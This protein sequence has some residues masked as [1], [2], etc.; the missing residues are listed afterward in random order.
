M[1]S[2]THAVSLMGEPLKILKVCGG[3]YECP[4][5]SDGK[6]L[7][8]LVG[9]AGRYTTS[10]HIQKQ[11]VGDVYVN[12]AKAEECPHVLA[13]FSRL[14]AAKSA[15]FSDTDTLCGVPLG[16]YGLSQM[17]GLT[18]DRRVIK[19]EKKVTALADQNNREQSN[20]VFGR[21]SIGKGE[22]IVIVEDVCNNFSTTKKLIELISQA[23]GIVS[24]IVCFLNRS[25]DVKD[26]Y[27][28]KDSIGIPVVSLVYKPILE[29]QQ[30]DPAVAQDI[31][32]GNVAWKPKDEWT[33]LIDAMAW[34]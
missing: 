24:A 5:A 20:L 19:V 3:Y 29:Y 32:D 22:K 28:M 6:R 27:V 15:I 7:G 12:F 21:H 11:W 1:L 2:P 30:D 34:K 18:L 4:K 23:G 16:G 13:H 33:K 17:L 8:P 25:L 14:I 9:Y 31:A 26:I 10:D